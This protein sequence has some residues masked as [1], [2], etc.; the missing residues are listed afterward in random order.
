M[1]DCVGC[2]VQGRIS[3]L[4]IGQGDDAETFVWCDLNETYKEKKQIFPVTY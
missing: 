1:D 2:D 3:N 4:G